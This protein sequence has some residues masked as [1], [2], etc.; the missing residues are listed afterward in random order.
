[1]SASLTDNFLKVA[2]AGSETTLGGSG[3][4]IGGTSWTISSGTGWPTDTAVVF[5][6]RQVDSSGNEVAGTYTEWLGTLSGTT[7]T[8]GSSPAYGTDQNYSAGSTTQVYVPVSS[9]AY[10]R[11]LTALLTQHKQSGAHSALTADTV[12]SAGLTT[13]AGIAS[14]GTNT[15]AGLMDAWIGANESWTYASST[16]ITVP[17]D[18]TTKYDIGDYIKLTQSATVKYFVVTGVTSTVLTVS[19]LSGATVANS[20][21]TANYY[22]KARMP[23]GF[24]KGPGV[25]NPY[26]F[27]VYRNAALT[28]TSGVI[29]FDTK[30]YDTGSNVDV[31]TN[32]GRFTA[33]VAGFYRFTARASATTSTNYLYILLRIDGVNILEGTRGATENIN[34]VTGSMVSAE[35]QLNANDY[36]E[37][38]G[39]VY[40]STTYETGSTKLYFMGSLLSLL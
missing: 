1:M 23:H 25:Y 24:P 38:Y 9:Y 19:G 36:V 17:T 29:P 31:V 10:N 20:A 7:L 27:S 22:S 12:T 40:T 16:T 11:M 5:A 39:S 15:F 28:Q 14:T 6:V 34:N 18:A 26:K 4:S 21:I 32:K 13:T 30:N 37:I 2:A 33:P 35:F 3:H 8:T